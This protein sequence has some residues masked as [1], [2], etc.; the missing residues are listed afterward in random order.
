MYVKRPWTGI[1]NEQQTR[2][3]DASFIF[4]EMLRRGHYRQRG[5][6]GAF[7]RESL[8]SAP[9]APFRDFLGPELPIARVA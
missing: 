1:E 9:K 8:A 7:G 2:F 6:L 5:D 4:Q 3:F